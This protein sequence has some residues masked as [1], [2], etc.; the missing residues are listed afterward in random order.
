MKLV[1]WQSFCSAKICLLQSAIEK[2]PPGIYNY[3]NGAACK[4]EVVYNIFSFN[5]LPMLVFE[6]FCFRYSL[7]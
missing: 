2:L 3:N 4:F 5:L 7:Q 6:H 1:G